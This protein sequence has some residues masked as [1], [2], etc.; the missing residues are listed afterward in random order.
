MLWK[1]FFMDAFLALA[2]T[3]LALL[4]ARLLMTR[5]LDDACLS[6]VARS[7]FYL[8][9]VFVSPYLNLVLG[10]VLRLRVRVFVWAQV[11]VLTVAWLS[12]G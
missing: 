2:T 3:F 1:H 6:S 7:L 8:T 4:P 12:F 5:A 11:L 10:V 9:V